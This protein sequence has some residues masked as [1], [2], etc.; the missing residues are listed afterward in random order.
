MRVQ[1]ANFSGFRGALPLEWLPLP[2]ICNRFRQLPDGIIEGSV[3]LRR[4]LYGHGASRAHRLDAR[5]YWSNLRD[6]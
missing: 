5:L 1:D 4:P 3:H 6:C 2:E